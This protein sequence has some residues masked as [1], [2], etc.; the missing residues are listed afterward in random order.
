MGQ[1]REEESLALTSVQD[2][3]VMKTFDASVNVC[4]KPKQYR[5]RQTIVNMPYITELSVE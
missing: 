1:E 5:P 3:N 4:A 2:C